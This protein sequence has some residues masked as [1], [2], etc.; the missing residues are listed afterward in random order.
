MVVFK[1]QLVGRVIG[2]AMQKTAK[3]SVD[4]FV[5]HP[6]YKRVRLL[7]FS[8]LAFSFVFFGFLLSFFGGGFPRWSVPLTPSSF[9]GRAAY[10]KLPGTRREQ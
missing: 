2:T 7:F 9:A 5:M 6:L 8:F 1:L 3:V 10:E 4:R